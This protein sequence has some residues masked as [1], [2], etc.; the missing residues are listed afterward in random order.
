MK[1]F[2]SKKDLQE[3]IKEQI[4]SSDNSAIRAMLRIFEY[5]TADE[6]SQG[7]TSHYNGVGF[8]GG[9]AEILTSFTNQVS[10]TGVLSLKQMIVLKKIIGKYAGQLMNQAID[11]GIY[12]KVNGV[13]VI[14]Q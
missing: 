3:A 4:T 5:Q 9:D 7:V 11:K 8:T 2:K 6:Q 10:R 12:Q 14:N 13:W 1:T